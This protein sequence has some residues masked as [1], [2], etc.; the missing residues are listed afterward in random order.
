[1]DSLAAGE[2]D[3]NVIGVLFQASS[4]VTE[5]FRLCLIQILL[6]ARGIKLN[7]VTTLYYVAP[8]CFGFLSVPFAA[9]ELPKMRAAPAPGEEPWKIPTAWLLASCTCAFGTYTIWMR[10]E[11]TGGS[12]QQLACA[13]QTACTHGGVHCAHACT[14]TVSLAYGLPL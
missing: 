8:A 12:G 1:M 2:I 11:Y 10:D 14:S 4:I 5:S 7:P 13:T 3:F 9:L 6:Q